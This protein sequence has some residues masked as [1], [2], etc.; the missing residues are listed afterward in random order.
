MKPHIIKMVFAS[1]IGGIAGGIV[2]WFLS[3]YWLGHDDMWWRYAIFG[4]VVAVILF[5]I[6]YCTDKRRKAGQTEESKN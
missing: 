2:W 1:L 3:K 6:L 4:F 5:C